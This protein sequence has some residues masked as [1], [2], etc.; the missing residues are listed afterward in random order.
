MHINSSTAPIAKFVQP[1]N[2][3]STSI[4]KQSQQTASSHSRVSPLQAKIPALQPSLPSRAM[5]VMPTGPEVS[6]PMP[7]RRKEQQAVYAIA[8]VAASGSAKPALSLQRGQGDRG[9]KAIPQA[10]PYLCSTEE[11]EKPRSRKYHELSDGESGSDDPQVLYRAL[12]EDEDPAKGL[13][14]P[15]GFDPSISGQAHV[16]AGSRA[17]KKS[18][19][20]SASRSIKPPA[21]WQNEGGLV[22][23][24]KRP[25][26]G[27]VYDLTR[28]ED[29]KKIFAS[30]NGRIANSAKASQEVI[31]TGT[32]P[33]QDIIKVY[34]VVE[35]SNDQ[36]Y[37]SIR[38]NPYM[39]AV[40]TRRKADEE[41]RRLVLLAQKFNPADV[42]HG[43][44]L[45]RKKIT[46]PASHGSKVGRLPLRP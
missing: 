6:G 20:V 31:F 25:A 8:C 22:V 5:R 14:A 34:K 45:P 27:K 19:F 17:K 43:A 1:V 28:L 44:V 39:K 11:K 15:Y 16:A 21:A 35:E 38:A 30:P 26:S 36:S 13:R 29:R 9:E 4:F 40:R 32:V 18:R 37:Q 12:R 2:T 24:F 33:P 3:R 46:V 23:K 7:Q 41:P 42:A 10:E